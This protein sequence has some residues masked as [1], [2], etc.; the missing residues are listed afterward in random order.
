M[1]LDKKDKAIIKALEEDGRALIRDIAKKTGIPRDSVNYRIKKLRSGTSKI[2]DIPLLK[3][4]P[5]ILK[6]SPF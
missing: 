6:F 4:N 3:S 1:K 5:D 2:M